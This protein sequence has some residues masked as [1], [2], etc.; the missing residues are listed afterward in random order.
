MSSEVVART[1]YR[2][3]LRTI[4]PF[5]S[6]DNGPILCSLL[7]R[8]G[9]DDFMVQS[10]K[11]EQFEQFAEQQ[12]KQRNRDHREEGSG[13]AGQ[14]IK[15][16]TKEEKH[17]EDNVHLSREEARDLSRSY[18][19]L[20]RIHNQNQRDYEDRLEHSNDESIQNFAHYTEWLT[21]QQKKGNMNTASNHPVSNLY[22][23][24]QRHQRPHILLYQHLLRQ[25][26]YNERDKVVKYMNFP[27]QTLNVRTQG[28]SSSLHEC[29]MGL[30][31]KQILQREFRTNTIH[32]AGTQ[33]HTSSKM[34]RETGFL[35][36]RELQEKLSWAE[37]M[38]MQHLVQR[39]PEAH[40]D[41]AKCNN[42]EE[43]Q[44]KTETTTLGE[45]ALFK[46]QNDTLHSNNSAHD[47]A[48][49]IHPLPY[50]QPSSY[51]QPGA[52]LVA[53]PMMDGIFAKSVICILQHTE[54]KVKRNDDANKGGIGEDSPSLDCDNG[55]NN[56][57]KIHGKDDDMEGRGKNQGIMEN[58]DGGTYGLIINLP[59][60]VGVPNPDSA[61]RR[62]N[63]TLREVIRHDSLPEGVKEAFGDCPV[64][65]GGPVNLS[66]Q[67]LRNSSQEDEEKLNIGGTVLPSIINDALELN[68]EVTSTAMYSDNA[69]YFG[70]DIIKAAQAVIDG[71]LKKGE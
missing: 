19:E 26:F 55:D 25:L 30:R 2:S 52:F 37:S 63:R 57:G 22:L 1:L 64:L 16:E 20:Q 18:H 4:K 27:S 24:Q 9:I 5:T 46:Q 39:Q 14:L 59:I 15:G 53:H 67:M 13:E 58:V 43:E 56:N 7:Y 32:Y 71:D 41:I 51:L 62:R 69:I 8:N 70:G 11:F 60:T 61:N 21:T 33:F 54:R 50:Y 31:M 12:T 45:E 29:A 49:N 10:P 68:G 28:D 34:K 40:T 35:V 36:L 47:A 23:Q 44:K 38:G 48:N 6:S 42:D 65:N 17:E 66:I 3:L